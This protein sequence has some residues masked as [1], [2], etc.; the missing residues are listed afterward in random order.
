ML[1]RKIALLFV[2]AAFCLAAAAQLPRQK[3]TVNLRVRVVELNEHSLDAQVMVS[4]LTASGALIAQSF[5]QGNGEVEFDELPAGSYRLRVSGNDVEET[6][7]DAFQMLAM[8]NTHIETV[9]VKVLQAGDTAGPVPGGTVSAAEMN[10]PGKAKKEFRKGNE[11][12]AA[13]KVED[14]RQ[15]YTKAIE[16]YPRYPSAY[17]NMGVTWMKSGD[18]AQARTAFSKALEIDPSNAGASM[19]LG[20]LAYMDHNWTDAERYLSRS[21]SSNPGDVEALAMLANVE[22]ELKKFDAAIADAQKVHLLAH[23]KFA[24]V[25]LIAARALEAKGVPDEAMM[26]YKVF[27]KEAPNA[28]TAPLAREAL[29]RL[30]AGKR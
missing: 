13:G 10:V 12:F 9:R 7:T 2:L 14:A 3:Q 5:T 11:A 6:T 16:I 21:S 24:V 30:Q 20:R 29:D 17:N 4:L 23:Q 25:H 1:Y 22:L 8:E 15:H 18:V 26:E 28:P 19:N 27:L